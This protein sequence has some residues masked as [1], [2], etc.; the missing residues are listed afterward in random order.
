MIEPR[1]WR[2]AKRLW[3]RARRAAVSQ[4]GGSH[5]SVFRGAGLS[6]EEVRPYEPGDDVRTID[7]NVT[8]RLGQ[9]FV[10]RFVEERELPWLLMLDVSRSMSF[11]T[12]GRSKRDAAVEV[13]ALAAAIALFHHDRVGLLLFS[14]R[15]EAWLP[16]RKGGRAALKLLHTALFRE[17]AG[18]RTRLDLA[19]RFAARA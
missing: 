15:I 10:K 12:G 7:W 13:A 19:L 1:L 8:A 5:R 16:P 17:A 6:F 2:Q 11:G 18:R 3:L 14:D 4:L 9:P